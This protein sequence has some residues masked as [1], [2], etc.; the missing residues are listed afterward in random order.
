MITVCQNAIVSPARQHPEAA[1]SSKLFPDTNVPLAALRTGGGVGVGKSQSTWGLCM[2]MLQ[3]P[4]KRANRPGTTLKAAWPFSAFL[5]PL[6]VPYERNVNFH[7]AWPV[8]ENFRM[9]DFPK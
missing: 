3:F 4:A 7:L 1:T 6:K 9:G 5:G 8:L 2:A